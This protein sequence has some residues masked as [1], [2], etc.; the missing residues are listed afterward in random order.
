MDLMT[1]AMIAK[2]ELETIKQA[3][4]VDV[5]EGAPIPESEDDP[6]WKSMSPKDKQEDVMQIICDEQIKKLRLVKKFGD[7][8]K[9]ARIVAKCF[10]KV[11]ID[12]NGDVDL[13]RI[14]PRDAIYEEIEGDDFIEK[15]VVKGARQTMPLHMV[16]MK[17]NFTEEERKKIESA[18]ANFGQNGSNQYRIRRTNNQ[19]MIDVIHVEWKSVKPSYY[20]I[21]PIS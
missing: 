19:V 18:T 12:Q 20:K 15:S 11:E 14:D 3:A 7:L 17:F 16:L 4:G 9:D 8:F 6:I 1:G 21:M 2:S 10:A 5:M 13:L